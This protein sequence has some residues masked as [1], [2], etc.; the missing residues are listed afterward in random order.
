MALYNIYNAMR[1]HRIFERFGFNLP[2]NMTKREP[3]NT[4]VDHF[5]NWK[6]DLK[7]ND[8]VGEDTAGLLTNY[9][10][11]ERLMDILENRMDMLLE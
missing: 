10:P 7:H 9:V 6:Y 3:K 1:G 8:W 4:E 11:E 2:P 5:I